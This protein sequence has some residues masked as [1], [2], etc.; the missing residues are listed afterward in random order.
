MAE[1]RR[2][3][4]VLHLVA[5]VLTAIAGVVVSLGHA[6]DGVFSLN[7]GVGLAAEHELGFGLTLWLFVWSL[8]SLVWATTNA[9][10]LR[11]ERRRWV[12]AG[13]LLGGP[14]LLFGTIIMFRVLLIVQTGW[15]PAVHIVSWFALVLS[16]ISVGVP[17]AASTAQNSVKTL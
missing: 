12:W 9:L 3:Y 6:A 4:T 10:C 8:V 13:I 1:P 2:W 15:Q 14:W 16:F 17:L 5:V 11:T 7:K